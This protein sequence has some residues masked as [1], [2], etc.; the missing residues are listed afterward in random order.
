MLYFS[1][2]EHLR[3]HWWVM[4]MEVTASWDRLSIHFCPFLHF[5]FEP[6]D[7]L[8]QK[9]IY[10]DSSKNIFHVTQAH[11]WK[12]NL[13]L[14]KV[15]STPCFPGTAGTAG[16]RV[17]WPSPTSSLPH[18]LYYAMQWQKFQHSNCDQTVPPDGQVAECIFFEVVRQRFLHL[19]QPVPR[20]GR[21]WCKWGGWGGGWGGG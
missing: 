4:A 20:R 21:C 7:L 12:T 5:T 9:N 10:Y 1:I 14:L 16:R 13:A 18:L 17:G 11:Q 8:I 15:Y 3:K 6:F 2:C 19:L